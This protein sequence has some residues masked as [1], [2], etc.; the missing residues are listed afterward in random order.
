MSYCKCGFQTTHGIPLPSSSSISEEK[1][2]QKTNLSIGAMIGV[3]ATLLPVGLFMA[4]SLNGLYTQQT[5]YFAS[6]N[7]QISTY[8]SGLDNLIFLISF[9]ALLAMIGV[10]ALVLGCLSQFSSKAR[11]ALS[12][13]DPNGRIGNGLL[14]A[15]F[16]AASLFSANLIQQLYRATS[17]SWYEP[18]LIAFI[19]CG[20]VAISIGALL[21][22]SSYLRSRLATKV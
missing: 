3:G 22:R 7:I 6:M 2:E 21:I 20:L 10:Y 4:F 18:L 15:G 19:V 14:N 9:G 17:S 8:A 11:I 5:G 12:M 1:N 13:K 16:L